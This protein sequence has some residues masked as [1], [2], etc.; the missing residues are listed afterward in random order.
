VSSPISVDTE[1]LNSTSFQSFRTAVRGA[2]EEYRDGGEANFPLVD[3]PS[4]ATNEDKQMID[5]FAGA[6]PNGD[7][8][9]EALE[10]AALG[11]ATKVD[12]LGR[13][14]E[15]A[16]EENAQLANFGTD[17]DGRR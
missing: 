12:L 15:V 9:L 5:A 2:R 7:L 6:Y 17:G 4:R 11:D 8:M 16:E 14:L 3:D 10:G 1:L 13:I